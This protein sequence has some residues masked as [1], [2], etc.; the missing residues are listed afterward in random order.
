MDTASWMNNVMEVK[1]RGYA[2]SGNVFVK[3]DTFYIIWNVLTVGL[4]FFFF[5]KKNTSM[6]LKMARHINTSFDGSI[7]NKS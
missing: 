3:M 7:K 1:I 5:T 4:I 2:N 6:F